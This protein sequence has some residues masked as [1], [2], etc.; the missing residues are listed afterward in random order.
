MVRIWF[1]NINSDFSLSVRGRDKLINEVSDSF[2]VS[3]VSRN[4]DVWFSFAFSMLE[5]SVYIEA[6]EVGSDTDQ[7][8]ESNRLA[9]VNGRIG[10]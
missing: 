4:M 8:M 7:Q 3:F 6:V 1:L 10:V 5:D 2:P 9:G